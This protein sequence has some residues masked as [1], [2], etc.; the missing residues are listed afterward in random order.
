MSHVDDAFTLDLFDTTQAPLPLL[1]QL[2]IW[3]TEGILRQLDVAW[4]QFVRAQ[5][6]DASDALLLAATLLTH[7]EGRGHSCLPLA[8]V[9]RHPSEVLGWESHAQMQLQAQLD[10]PGH[11][12]A[13]WLHALSS[14]AL[15]RVV[16]RDA[17]TGQPMV[18]AGAHTETPL[19]YLRRYWHHERLVAQHIQARCVQ[20]DAVDEASAKKWLERL[21][22]SSPKTANATACDWQSLACALALRGRLTIITGGP[23]TGKTYTAA[24]LLALLWGTSP[25]R[26]TCAGHWQPPPARRRRASSSRLTRPCKSCSHWSPRIWTCPRWSSAPARHARC[27]A[28]W[29][30]SPARASGATTA[31]IRWKWMCSSSMKPRWCTWK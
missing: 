27:T 5:Q 4:M 14:S 12:L 11:S 28:C 16:D 19:L 22:P 20:P 30:A 1:E 13:Q 8:E 17:D 7:L 18:L 26:P 15:V 6:S 3:Q 9:L 23:G 29:A 25:R 24:R 10:L 21:F 2:H 31:T